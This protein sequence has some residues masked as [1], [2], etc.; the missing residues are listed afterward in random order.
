MIKSYVEMAGPSD[1]WARGKFTLQ[2]HF[3]EFRIK[4]VADESDRL[5]NLCITEHIFKELGEIHWQ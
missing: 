5:S 3:V 1:E 2:L 4:I